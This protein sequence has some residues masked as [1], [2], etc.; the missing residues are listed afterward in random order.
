MK[1]SKFV[2]F[3]LFQHAILIKHRIFCFQFNFQQKKY[4]LFEKNFKNQIFELF[5]KINNEQLLG[6]QIFQISYKKFQK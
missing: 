1:F 2:I 4:D 3:E 5:F 6:L